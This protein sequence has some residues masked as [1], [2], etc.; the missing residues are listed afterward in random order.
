MRILGGI[1]VLQ[2]TRSAAQEDAHPRPPFTIIYSR[3][4][5]GERREKRKVTR[6]GRLLNPD[7]TKGA[8][9]RSVAMRKSRQCCRAARRDSIFH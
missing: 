5:G 7:E 1:V 2:V 9:L 8:K 3:L 6:R 4:L